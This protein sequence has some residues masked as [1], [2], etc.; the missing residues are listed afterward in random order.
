MGPCCRYLGPEVPTQELIWQDPIPKNNY[1]LV[2]D[3]DIKKLKDIITN[4]ELTNSELISTA[5]ASASTY[6]ST[7]KR[8]GANGA[9]IAL[10][11]QIDWEINQ[12]KKLKKII[13]KLKTIKDSFNSSDTET[14]ISLADLIVLGG[15]VGIENSA[16]KAG[17][18]INIEL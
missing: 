7:D 9:R 18:K 17:L 11:P 12:P 4:S 15:Y 6:R 8:G 16:R 1:N 3:T 14:K 10:K 2:N 13:E 5:W